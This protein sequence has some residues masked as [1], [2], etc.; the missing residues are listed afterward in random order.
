MPRPGRSCRTAGSPR[1]PRSI[2][3]VPPYLVD[4]T[5]TRTDLAR[6]YDEIH[7]MD[8]Q[9]GQ[10]CRTLK[11]RGMA[12]NTLVIFL[13]D[14]GY[15]FPR[16]KST[17]YDDGI[18]TPLIFS[19]NG[20]I[21]K[22]TVHNNGLISTIDLMPTLLEV[23]GMQPPESLYGESF[24]EILENPATRGREM[25]FAERNWHGADEHMRCIR[26]EKYKLIRTAYTDKP[27]GMGSDISTSPSWFSLQEARLKGSL[28]YPQ[29][30]IFQAP[31]PGIELYDIQED[32]YEIENLAYKAG[33]TD[34]IKDLLKKLESWQKE[35]A[36]HHPGLRRIPDAVDRRTGQPMYDERRNEYYSDTL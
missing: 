20:H 30:L 22:G 7:R 9:I 19:W 27:L 15:P 1:S 28:T 35:T 32:P 10:F 14:N 18:Q 29:S 3:N 23:A 36:D 13:S 21:E 25:I 16:G 26:T 34:I 4:D 2:R 17:V 6:Y 5:Q 24:I 33:Y 8:R 11:S 12:E 31:R